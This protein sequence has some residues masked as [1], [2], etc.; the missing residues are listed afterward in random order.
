[1]NRRTFLV[2]TGA[3]A[4][5]SLTSAVHAQPR[6]ARRPRIGVL[7]HAANIEEETPYYQTLLE[8]FKQLGYVE[9]R[10][11]VL[12]HRFPDEKPELF[13][14]MAAELVSSP[15]GRPRRT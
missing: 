10:T 3:M 9:G 8:G 12:E 11:I 6:N 5:V 15:S 13:T 4:G 1:M 7:W 14:K 2:G